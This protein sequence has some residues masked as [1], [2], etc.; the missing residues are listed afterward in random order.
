MV[1]VVVVGAVGFFYI[2]IYYLIVVVYNILL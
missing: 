1:E 2:R